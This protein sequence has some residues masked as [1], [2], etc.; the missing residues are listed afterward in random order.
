MFSEQFGILLLLGGLATAFVVTIATTLVLSKYAER[1]G[2][3]DKP[4]HRKIHST[5][6]PRIGGLGIFAGLMV[7]LLYFSFIRQAWPLEVGA[8]AMPNIYFMTG[9]IVIAVTGL[10]DDFKGIT[11]RQK[12][13][14][15]C[16]IAV[17]IILAGYRLELDFGIFPGYAHMVSIPVTFLWIIG[18]INAVN[19]IDG[20]DGLA[21]GTFMISLLTL[22]ICYWLMGS[23]LDLVFIF[24]VS[25]AVLGFLTLN[26][27]PA[28]VFMGDTG[29]LFLGYVIACYSL[30]TSTLG[31][32]YFM[33][34]VPILAV[35]LPVFDTLLSMSRRALRGRPVFYPDKDHIHHRVRKVFGGTQ[36]IAV[37]RLYYINLVLGAL[38]ILLCLANDWMALLILFLAALYIVAVVWR[39]GY[40]NIREMLKKRRKPKH[41]GLLSTGGAFPYRF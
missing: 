14:A 9:G 6:I 31:D 26:T 36:R 15:Q 10:V 7:S 30:K 19:L 4:D 35:G 24:A 39:L 16:L 20:M 40:L 18:V 22:T 41:R 3:I 29:S 12:L 2:L 13:V 25:G 17:Y 8:L 23:T 5:P 1:L 37:A 27:H 11:F 38:A 33:F 32:N 34:M 21:G 28:K